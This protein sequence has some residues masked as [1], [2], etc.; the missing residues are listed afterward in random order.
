MDEHAA[1][2]A[3]ADRLAAAGDDAAVLPTAGFDAQLV[4]STDMLHASADFPAATTA[5]TRGWRAVAASLSD[6]AAMGARPV[7]AVAVIAETALEQ[8]SIDAVIDGAVAACESVGASYVGGDLDVS[9]E[10]SVVSTAVG[11]ADVPVGRDG[12]TAGESV[13]VTGAIG[14]TCAAM[15]AFDAGETLA[16][17]ELMRFTPRCALGMA[18]AGRATAMI[19]SSDGLVRSLYQLGRASGVGF[20]IEGAAVPTVS[21]ETDRWRLFTYGEDFELVFTA[22]TRMVD[23]LD[24]ETR[25][26]VTRIGRVQ[27]EEGVVVDGTLVRDEGYSHE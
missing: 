1:L 9:P 27:S 19:D 5:Y 26:A 4:I 8:R 15:A 10:Q 6:I 3:I 11:T 7:A 13:Y 2:V 18:L 21:V 17:N 22:P 20:A 25:E 12:A 23:A 14:R 24:A 16:A